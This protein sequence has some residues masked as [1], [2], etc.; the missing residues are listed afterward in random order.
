MADAPD[1]F[2][3]NQYSS[4]VAMIDQGELAVRL[5]SLDVYD[6][7]GKVIWWYD[8]VQHGKGFLHNGTTTTIYP[9]MVWDHT[10]YRGASLAVKQIRASADNI[11][12]QR[13]LVRERSGRIG[14]EVGVTLPEHFGVLD[15][16]IRVS[17]ELGSLD[18][19]IRFDGSDGYV[20]VQ[21]PD[22]SWSNLCEYSAYDE[23]FNIVHQVKL[24][25]DFDQATFF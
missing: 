11:Y 7:R 24:A 8:P 23:L 4:K 16:S 19:T 21:N 20:K 17:D 25:V 1:Y 2:I 22:L 3:Y 12:L 6:R 10:L 14:F 18:G 15:M 5:G 9:Y 13:Y